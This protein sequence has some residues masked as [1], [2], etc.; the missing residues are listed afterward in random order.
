[1]NLLSIFFFLFFGFDINEDID[2]DAPLIVIVTH[3]TSLIRPDSAFLSDDYVL[4]LFI[5]TSFIIIQIFSEN[6][7]KEYGNR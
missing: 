5:A 6:I 7:I 4:F 2:N 3:I 1:M